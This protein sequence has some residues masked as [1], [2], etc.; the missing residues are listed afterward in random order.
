QI[1][2]DFDVH[3]A[4][5]DP[6]EPLAAFLGQPLAEPPSGLAAGAVGAPFDLTAATAPLRTRRRWH[7]ALEGAHQWNN[8]AVALAVMDVLEPLGLG[9]P[10]AAQQQGL[11]RV[12][13]AARI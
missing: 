6:A 13:C 12:H 5:D 10:L 1:G 2:A 9:V 11:S 7:V 4:A 8:A 3:P